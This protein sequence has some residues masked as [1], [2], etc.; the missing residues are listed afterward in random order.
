MTP[1]RLRELRELTNLSQV[2]LAKRA[3]IDRSRLSMFENGH[4]DLAEKQKAALTTALQT[5]MHERSL[6]QKE[7]LNKFALPA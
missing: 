7:A 2:E 5:A 1:K 4:V 3:G 6:Q